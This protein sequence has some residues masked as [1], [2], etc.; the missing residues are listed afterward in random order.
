MVGEV[1]INSKNELVQFII[2]KRKMRDFVRKGI[3]VFGFIV[4]C[5][6]LITAI[7][8]REEISNF[9]NKTKQFVVETSQSIF[10]T[11]V[12]KISIHIFYY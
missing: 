6:L 2:L 11:Q 9:Y 3:M 12:N 5:S 4:A 10:S 8:F 1:K 7:T